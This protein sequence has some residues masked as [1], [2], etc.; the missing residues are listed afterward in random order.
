MKFKKIKL[1]LINGTENID[2][3]QLVK[4]VTWSGSYQQACRKLEFSLLASP[5]DKSI[6][7]VKIECGY[8]VRLLEEDN[9][10]F[11]GYIQSRNLSYSGNSVE[12]MALDGGTYVHRNELVYNFKNQTAESIASKVC[13]DLGI[14]IGSL[15]S[16]GISMDKKFFGV[17]GY[18]IIMTAY[19]YASTKTNKKYMCTMDK[20]QLN[21]IEKGEITLELNFE[22][23]SNI[24]DSNFSEDISNM[25]N[26]VKVYNG[27]EQEVKVISNSNDMKSY[28]TFTKI[29]KLEDGKDAD[30]EAKKEL[31]SIERKASITGFGD[32]SCKSGYGVKVKD[33]YTNLVG[34][35]YID[36]DVHTWEDGIYKVDL[37]LAFENMM[38]EVNSETT[39][40]NSSSS[41]SG[42]VQGKEV[43]AIFTAYYPANNSMQGGFY[44]AQGN[45]LDPSKLTCASPKSVAFGTMVKVLN[46]G[47]DRDNLVYKVTDRG[48]AIVIKDGVYH[49]DLLMKDKKTAYAFGRRKGKAIIGQLVSSNQSSSSGGNSKLVELA[50]SKLGCKYVWGA[51]GANTFDCSGLTYWCHKQIGISIPRTSLEQSRSGKS[52]SKSDLQAGDLVFFKTTSAPV[53]HV[54]MYVGNGQF[55]HA[56]NKSKPVKYDSLS[57]SY[58]SSRYVNARR[59]W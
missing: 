32:S 30:A 22:N 53:G 34:L 52:V 27:D 19:T 35:F 9:E 58:Y 15:A 50:K 26:K 43:D 5:Y 21:V 45:K 59:Y 8:M 57:S 56:P 47:T 10:L 11:R 29:L 55:I 48:G 2:I 33:A 1:E 23:G 36:E 3:T 20:G 54:G 24:L 7:T 17:S 14:S 25:V 41:N 42:E 4:N 38:H 28:G 44:D 46:T 31:K 37:T 16:T 40:N 12:Y 18:D 51:T 39:E 6:P 13:S 49:F